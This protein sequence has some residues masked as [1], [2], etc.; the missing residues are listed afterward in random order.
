L[1]VVHIGE[2]AKQIEDCWIVGR[3]QALQEMLVK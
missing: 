1:F 2:F 3:R